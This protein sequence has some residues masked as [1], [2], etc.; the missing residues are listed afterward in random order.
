MKSLCLNVE[1]Q[2]KNG[3]VDANI[4]EDS[5]DFDRALFDVLKSRQAEPEA[6]EDAGAIEDIEAELGALLQDMN[7]S[8]IDDLFNGGEETDFAELIKN[9]ETKDEVDG[10]DDLF[11]LINSGEA[12]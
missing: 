3:L 5:G 2:G 1:L 11:G 7:K 8:G 6:D 10:A 9:K 12:E 4:D